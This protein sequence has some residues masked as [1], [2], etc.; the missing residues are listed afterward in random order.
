MAILSLELI[1]A[2]EQWGLFSHVYYF[3]LT[4]I[5]IVYHF[6]S[7]SFSTMTASYSVVNEVFFLLDS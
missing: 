6:I 7:Q 3:E 1:G 4:G 5:G 2:Y